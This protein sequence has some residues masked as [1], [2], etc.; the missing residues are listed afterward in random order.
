MT[1]H[2][3]RFNA[4]ILTALILLLVS[5]E[6]HEPTHALADKGKGK[7]MLSLSTDLSID[8]KSEASPISEFDDYRF[9]F[10]GVDGYATSDYYRYGDV[11][12]YGDVP[13]TM[14][15]YLGIF[16]LQA[17]SCTAEQAETG[18]GCLR[19]EGISQPF[20]IINDQTATA[21]VICTVANVLVKV[22]FDDSMYQ[23]F[24]D[25]KLTVKSVT[26]PPAEEGSEENDEETEEF[27]PEVYHILDF[28]PFD[29]SG[30]FNLQDEPV[31]LQYVLYVK[32]SGAEVLVPA[33]EG[34]FSS[35]DHNAPTV[36]NAGDIITFNVEYT[37]EVEV[38]DGIKFI[39]DGAKTTVSNG[40]DL[41]DYVTGDVEEDA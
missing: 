14:T 31:N 7:V 19:Y 35:G 21:S 29:L 10:V 18:R 24:D 37:G 1:L 4:L 17:E 40:L 3:G 16:R 2:T 33:V 8:I 26:A 20:S 28:T 12:S 6:G 32:M 23:A 9:R 25:Y 5:C 41:G 38:T 11:P 34:Y 27:V 36:I 22:N 13:K 39:V 15:W 30:Y